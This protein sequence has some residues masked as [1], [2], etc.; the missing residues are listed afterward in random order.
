MHEKKNRMNTTVGARRRSSRND[1][2]VTPT[3]ELG[4]TTSDLEFSPCQLALHRNDAYHQPYLTRKIETYHQPYFRRV[5][6]P[7]G[8]RIG[9]YQQPYPPIAKFRIASPT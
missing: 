9:A 4:M 1:A 6:I 3:E 7:T 8:H 5:T 2:A